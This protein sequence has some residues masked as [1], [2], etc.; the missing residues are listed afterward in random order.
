LVREAMD[1]KQPGPQGWTD[2]TENGEDLP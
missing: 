1:P 2:Y